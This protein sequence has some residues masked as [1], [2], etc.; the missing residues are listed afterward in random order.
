MEPI[1]FKDSV[2]Y[3]KVAFESPSKQ[4]LYDKQILENP[5]GPNIYKT[6]SSFKILALEVLSLFPLFI[7]QSTL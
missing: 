6:P 2:I 5:T 7:P 1:L 4:L 3:Y